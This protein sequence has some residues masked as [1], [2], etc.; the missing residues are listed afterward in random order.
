MEVLAI[1]PARGGS[2]GIKKKNIHPVGLKPLLAFSI[3]DAK[4]VKAITRTVVSTDDSEIAE[5]AKKFGAEIVWRPDNISDDLSISEEALL[6]VLDYLKEQEKYEPDI[7]VFLQATSPLRTAKDIEA[8]LTK[9]QADKADSL[10][11]ASRLH[12]FIWRLYDDGPR[13]LNYD[14]RKRPMR[15]EA[16]LDLLESGSIYIFKP[17]VIRKCHNRLGGKISVYVMNALDAFQIDEPEDLDIM[18]RLITLKDQI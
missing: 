12:G 18:E 14:Y 3:E 13:P 10:L 9:F 15:Q 11:S 16:P 6:H 17:W 8:A 7:V 5:V 2:K 4:Q 1:I